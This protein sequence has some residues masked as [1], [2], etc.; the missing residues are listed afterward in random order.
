VGPG[1]TLMPQPMPPPV[2]AGQ[3]ESDRARA[4]HSSHALTSGSSSMEGNLV[5]VA[6]WRCD[7]DNDTAVPPVSIGSSVGGVQSPWSVVAQDRSSVRSSLGGGAT[8]QQQ[9]QQ[10]RLPR[11]QDLLDDALQQQQDDDYRGSPDPEQRQTA[12][13]LGCCVCGCDSADRRS[14]GDPSP[15]SSC[16]MAYPPLLCLHLARFLEAKDGS[17]LKRDT[18]IDCPL[19]GLR[20]QQQQQQ[21]QQQRRRGVSPQHDG[22]EYDDGY[23]YELFGVIDLLGG[24][25]GA[26]EEAGSAS[27]TASPRP[28]HFVA[29]VRVDD[30][31]DKEQQQ[32]LQQRW[33]CFDDTRVCEARTLNGNPVSKDSYILFY[34]RTERA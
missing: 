1:I 3:G 30:K 31:G 2:D 29:T 15:A 33:V 32:L 21:Q 27:A 25:A 6:D 23:E 4:G 24:G 11:L 10:Q 13:T 5:V 14:A 17:I 28:G 34:V 26:G 12:C 22:Q 18:L 8:T 9:Q 20:L 19:Q 7:S 16:G